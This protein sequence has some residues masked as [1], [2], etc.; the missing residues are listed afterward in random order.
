MNGTAPP[1][2]RKPI[3]PWLLVGCF[4]L[5]L[6]VVLGG[7]YLVRV[8]SRKL[9]AT[10]EDR[11]KNPKAREELALNMLRAE[12]LPAGYYPVSATFDMPLITHVRLSDRAPDAQGSVSGYDARGFVFTD[13]AY[14]ESSNRI[15]SFFTGDDGAPTAAEIAGIR[16][17]AKEDV[18]KGE[19]QDVNGQSIRYHTIRG[20][21]EEG[22]DELEGLITLMFIDCAGQE[23]RERTAIWFGPQGSE[24]G[25]DQA[26]RAFMSHFAV[27]KP[28][29]K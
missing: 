3:W 20:R 7:I 8:G 5:L 15:E 19:L 22:D 29:P 27:C 14:T 17:R 24:V 2:A 26:I 11:I 28:R 23:K 4:A 6:A 13:S 21:F 9:I 18:V 25:D 16:V 10:V 12:K 1:P